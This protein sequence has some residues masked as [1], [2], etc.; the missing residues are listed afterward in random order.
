[1]SEIL[2]SEIQGRVLRLSLNRPE[3]RN[4]LN[5]Q[6]CHE[7]QDAISHAN[8]DQKVGATLL[9]ANGT[10]FSAGMDLQEMGH[11]DEES[12]GHIQE[13]LFTMGLRLSKPVVAAVDGPALG[14]GFGVLANC[15]IVVASTKAK[16]GLTEINIGLW[17]FLIYRA[18]EIAIGERRLLELALT[19]R[20]F[21]AEEAQAM[22]LAQ[23]ID[24]DPNNK[25][26]E[27]AAKLANSSSMA[28]RS[29]LNF[30]QEI[31]GESQEMVGLLARNARKDVFESL[32][33]QEGLRAFREK[34]QPEWPSLSQ[35]KHEPGDETP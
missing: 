30:A 21:G 33:F 1:M 27:I 13:Q 24:E 7:L 3:K 18:V 31:R 32:D 28:I 14:G 6:L 5:S 34:R 10:C 4:A 25:A 20:I 15:H 11:V 26:M 17:P 23:V 19:G 9:M 22:G 16:F 8:H 35:E 12:L 2:Q 29:G